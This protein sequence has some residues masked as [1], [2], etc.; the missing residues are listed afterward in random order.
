MLLLLLLTPGLSARRRSVERSSTLA[1]PSDPAA[2]I[3]GVR[4]PAASLFGID[5]VRAA[6]EVVR[7]GG[8]VSVALAEALAASDFVTDAERKELIAGA[9]ARLISVAA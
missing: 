7:S 4:P 3:P 2:T 6:I 1:V 5:D 8:R 9:R